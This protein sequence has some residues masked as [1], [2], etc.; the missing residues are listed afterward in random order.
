MNCMEKASIVKKRALLFL[1]KVIIGLNILNCASSLYATGEPVYR[2]K[3]D[4]FQHVRSGDAQARYDLGKAFLFGQFGYSKNLV[5]AAKWFNAAANQEHADAIYTL[6]LMHMG[7]K[8][9]FR[10][11]KKGIQLF[12]R[13]AGCGSVGA[14]LCLGECHLMCYGVEF[15]SEKALNLFTAAKNAGCTDADDHISA[16]SRVCKTR[17]TT[18]PL[19]VAIAD[20]IAGTELDNKYQ[21]LLGL[22]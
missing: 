8:G 5:R 9:V 11:M 19:K 22:D 16:I 13:A 7:G 17:N 3:A 15:D 14:M 2:H 18:N 1:Q 10:D 4:L 12:E 20:I 21:K 6:A